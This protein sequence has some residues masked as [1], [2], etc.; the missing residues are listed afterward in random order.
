M[1][2]IAHCDRCWYTIRASNCTKQVYAKIVFQL[3]SG[4]QISLTP[5]QS[6]LNTT[7]E[8]EIS[9][10]PESDVAEKLLLLE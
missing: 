5:F 1:G 10:L 3:D 8:E 2:K 4:E 7:F 6:V 9:S